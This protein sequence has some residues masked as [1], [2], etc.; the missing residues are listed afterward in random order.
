MNINSKCD[1]E[2]YMENIFMLLSFLNSLG[3]PLR[4]PTQRG[5]TLVMMKKLSYQTQTITS[6]VMLS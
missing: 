1:S 3:E 2:K 4:Q 6:Q 5:V